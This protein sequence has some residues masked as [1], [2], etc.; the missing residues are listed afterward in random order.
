MT[1][2]IAG[3]ITMRGNVLEMLLENC[4]R[5]EA[6]RHR[7]VEECLEELAASRDAGEETCGRASFPV[8]RRLREALDRLDEVRRDWNELSRL[9]A[10]RHAGTDVPLPSAPMGGGH[11]LPKEASAV[12]SFVERESGIGEHRLDEVVG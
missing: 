6:K 1:T 3:G 8:E 11:P 5:E 4:R 9:L 10:P 7:E 2:G 12:H